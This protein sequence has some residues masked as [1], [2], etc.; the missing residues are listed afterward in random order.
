MLQQSDQPW[1]ISSFRDLPKFLKNVREIFLK[2]HTKSNKAYPPVQ[3][4]STQCRSPITIHKMQTSPFA[5]RR[6]RGGMSYKP[7][8]IYRQA[9]ENMK[10]P[11]TL[12]LKPHFIGFACRTGSTIQYCTK[13][14]HINPHR[15]ELPTNLRATTEN[16]SQCPKLTH[17]G[18][19]TGEKIARDT[20]FNEDCDFQVKLTLTKG[21][22]CFRSIY[23]YG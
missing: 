9:L 17:K 16:S 2:S 4:Q 10:T 21:I 5:N 12:Q 22:T 18:P 1:S 11:W 6:R 15:P 3:S 20:Q 8:T 23:G 19:I 7:F 13:T 14:R